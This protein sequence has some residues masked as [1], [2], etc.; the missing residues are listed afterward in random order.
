VARSCATLPPLP[1][2]PGRPS[3]CSTY[4]QV[5]R[6]GRS[7][8]PGLASSSPGR[9]A[10]CAAPN[11]CVWASDGAARVCCRAQGAGPGAPAPDGPA[12]D[13]GRLRGQALRRPG[14][15]PSPPPPPPPPPHTPAPP[16]AAAAPGGAAACVSR[17]LLTQ[18]AP[19]RGSAP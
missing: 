3:G 15:L 5:Y 2:S 1:P 6:S 16:P 17:L 10:W 8:L 9:L 12:A 11:A 4:E 19:R 14:E 7:L 18:P 13:R